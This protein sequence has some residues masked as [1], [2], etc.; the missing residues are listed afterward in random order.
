MSIQDE[1]QEQKDSMGSAAKNSIFANEQTEVEGRVFTMQPIKPTKMM[2]VMKAIAGLLG[3]GLSGEEGSNVIG[4]IVGALQD[5]SDDDFLR[6]A[7]LIL[8]RTTAIASRAV[9]IDSEENFNIAFEGLQPEAPIILMIEVLKYNKFPL[10]RSLGDVNI[11]EL[12]QK[13]EQTLSEGDILK[14]NEAPTVSAGNS[15]KK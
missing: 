2:K 13:F 15:Q 3:A 5:L 1:L 11:G 10:I 12:I 6:L 7:F 9:A 4:S 8:H 14:S